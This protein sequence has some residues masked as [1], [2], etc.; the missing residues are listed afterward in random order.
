[1]LKSAQEADKCLSKFI[2]C[3]Y[4]LKNRKLQFLQYISC[5]IHPFQFTILFYIRRTYRSIPN[6]NYDEVAQIKTSNYHLCSFNAQSASLSR[7]NWLIN[8]ILNI[9]VHNRGMLFL[10]ISGSMFGCY[11]VSLGCLTS[12]IKDVRLR[13]NLGRLI[14]R[15]LF[16]TEVP[17][18]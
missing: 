4:N 2:S 9:F 18:L 17:Q 6:K 11:S 14:E 5:L 8:E 10:T 12:S 7:K 15:L 13:V 16:L 1:M 3:S